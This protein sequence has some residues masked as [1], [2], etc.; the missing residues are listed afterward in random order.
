MNSDVEKLIWRLNLTL[1]GTW[2]AGFAISEV[3]ADEQ[4][5]TALQRLARIGHACEKLKDDW[6]SQFN[7]NPKELGLAFLRLW[8]K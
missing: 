8:E 5:W 2:Q 3:E 7:Q 4:A 6:E 1:Q